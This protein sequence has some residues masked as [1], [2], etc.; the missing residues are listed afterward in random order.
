LLGFTTGA[1]TQSF[2][3]L[4]DRAGRLRA[5]GAPRPTS[6]L[7]NSSF[8]TG[9]FGWRCT[10]TGVQS[11]SVF[12]SGGSPTYRIVRNRYVWRTG[13]WVRTGHFA[14]TVA[15]D[16]QGNPPASTNDFPRFLCRGLPRNIL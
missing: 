3:V 9:S 7:V 16:A 15:A 10:T 8:G 2:N 1:H 14:R 4:H 13:G 12:P 6:W 11:R 5:L